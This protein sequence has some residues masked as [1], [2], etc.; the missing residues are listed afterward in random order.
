MMCYYLNVHF[1]GQRINIIP[2]STRAFSKWSPSFRFPHQNPVCISF[3]YV[4][5]GAGNHPDTA[6]STKVPGV[7]YRR[8]GDRIA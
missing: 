6:S 2:S 8:S 1:Q 4:Q 7:L 3:R 5:T